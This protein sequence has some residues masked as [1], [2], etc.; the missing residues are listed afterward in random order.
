[1]MSVDPAS[2]VL[3]SV[4]RRGGRRVSC[5][6]GFHCPGLAKEL[7]VRMQG[8]LIKQFDEPAVEVS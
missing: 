5:D 1:M 8:E 4:G 7:P 2:W 6:A 3:I